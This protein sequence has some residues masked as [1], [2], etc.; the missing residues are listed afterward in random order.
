MVISISKLLTIGILPSSLK[1]AYYRM[2]GAKIGKN[3]RLGLFCTIEADTIEIGDNSKL[4]MLVQ[5]KAREFKMGSFSEIRMMTI[6]DAPFI[7][8]GNETIIMEQVGVGAMEM[9]DSKLEIGDRCKIFPYCFINPTR[10]VIIGDDVGVGG[11]NYIFTHGAWPNS[12]EGF[13]ISFGPVTLE[14]RVW[15]PWRV[16]V[17][18]NVTVGHDS[19]IAAGSVITKSIPPL[20]LAAGA[21]AS[22]KK[23]GNEFIKKPTMEE[24]VEKLTSIFEGFRPYL[25][26]N[27]YLTG[28]TTDDKQFTEVIW[29][30]SILNRRKKKL[31]TIAILRNMEEKDI[32]NIEPG[33]IIASL[34]GISEDIRMKLERMNGSWFDLREYVWKGLRNEITN[35]LRTF[36]SRYGIRFKSLDLNPLN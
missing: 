15:L 6:M 10:P 11:S 2:R 3:V 30:R 25:K 24:K 13:P 23:T 26:M 4:G 20:S 19:V 18:P 29:M 36:L 28:K 32:A 34:E 8:I 1:K 22:V 14:D 31:G 16:F 5:I 9:H 21:P 17:M 33:M 27:K 7:K 35:T 12:L